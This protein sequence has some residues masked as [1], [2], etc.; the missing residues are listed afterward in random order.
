MSGC[1]KSG[2]LRRVQ[3]IYF[4]RVPLQITV[5]TYNRP[6]AGAFG[7]RRMFR[8]LPYVVHSAGVDWPPGGGGGGEGK[9]SPRRRTPHRASPSRCITIS[10]PV[11]SRRPRAATPQPNPSAEPRCPKRWYRLWQQCV[12]T[13]RH[14][15]AET[16]A[17]LWQQQPRALYCYAAMVGRGM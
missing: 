4:P 1:K 10:P 11:A 17:I 9:I 8:W 15:A 2:T 14:G 12:S 5:S 13:R 16:W 7:V 6:S 3:Y